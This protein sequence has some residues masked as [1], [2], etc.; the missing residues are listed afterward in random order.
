MFS[1]MQ[2]IQTNPS[3]ERVLFPKGE[4]SLG[5]TRGVSLVWVLSLPHIIL[6]RRVPKNLSKGSHWFEWL[7]SPCFIPQRRAPKNSLSGSHWFECLSSPC[8]IPQRR[9]PKNLSKGSHCLETLFLI[10]LEKKITPPTT[11]SKTPYLF[12]KG[13]FLRTSPRGP[14]VWGCFF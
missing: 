7:S 12:P 13:E 9:V 2:Q 11:Q 4:F 14:I 1:C 8:F 6:Q 3:D 5:T 10:L